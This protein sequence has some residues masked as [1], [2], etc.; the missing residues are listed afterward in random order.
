MSRGLRLQIGVSRALRT[1]CST[2]ATPKAGQLYIAGT[3][4]SNKLG[5]GDTKDRETPTL[6][7][8]LQDVPIAHVNC[9]KY[10]SAAISADGDV[11]MW[12]LG[13]SGQLGLG[14]RS[15]KAPTPTKVDALSGCGIVQISCGMYHTLA[16]NEA[17][18]VY[19]MGFGG[20]FFNGA[21]GLGHGDRTQLETPTKLSAFGG[22]GSD[23]GLAA[24]TVSAGGY[25]SMALDADGGAWSWGRGEWGRLGHGD[26][27]D[28]LTPTRIEGGGETHSK[29]LP[30]LS[31]AFAADA[32]S[33]CLTE[34]GTV[35]T[36]GRNENW[37]LG[38]EVVGLLNAGQSLDAQQEPQAVELPTE[39]PVAM[40]SSG[41]LGTAALLADRTIYVMGMGRFFE[42]TKLAG[43]AGIDGT[44]VDM[45]LGAYHIGILTDEGRMFTFGTGTALALP[46]A[47]RPQWE[48]AEVTAHSL[49][50]RKVLSMSCGSYATA[51]IVA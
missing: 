28:C 48:L 43:A 18:E 41:E 46:K 35:Y 19:S 31:A 11:Y 37:Q 32:H 10:H 25:H 23:I 5:V 8:S 36:W 45:Q 33:G 40:L 27:S 50:G 42:P 4:E 39:S 49:E 26:S 2:A 15:T 38:Y 21:G 7:E 14:S 6:V 44:I 20:S 13:D 9:G 29:A 34:D 51:M 17:G 24:A 12:G 16:L 47:A 30:K 1:Y 3:G 22:T